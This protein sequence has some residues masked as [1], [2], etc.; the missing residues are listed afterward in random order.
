MLYVE[1]AAKFAPH[2][3]N[4]DSQG[5]W[6][7]FHCTLPEGYLPSDVDVNAPAVCYLPGGEVYSEYINVSIDDSNMTL[8]EI[9]FDRAA[10][11]SV[12][13]FGEVE[14]TVTGKL[15]DGYLFTGSDT[16]IL[17]NK[18]HKH[19][20]AISENWLWLG[21]GGENPGDLNGDGRVDFADFARLGE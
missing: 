15:T 7:K 20:K 3:L 16:I 18:A 10:F 4:T 14:V 5:Q 13:A 9:G 6:V 11:D 1:V 19:I 17:I 12:T 2:V 21:V 8:L